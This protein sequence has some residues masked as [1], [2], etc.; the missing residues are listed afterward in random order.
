MRTLKYAIL[1]L[2]NNE[3]MTGY[4]IGKEF[5]KDLGEFWN[6]KHSQ[7][8]PEL[9]KL[10]DEGLIVYE[11]QISGEI[12]E[13]KMYSITEE[14]KEAF[15]KWL[16][17]AEPLEPTPKDVFRLRMY[18]SNHLDVPTRIHLLEHQLLQ[19]QERLQHLRKNN[20][21]HQ[22]IPPHDSVDFGDYFILDGAILRETVT[23]QWL[24]NFIQYCKSL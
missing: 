22:S 23:I 1:G 3:P 24:E 18:F 2:L 4:D 8:Y 16:K 19:H 5:S 6:A 10:F 13:K 11:I 21:R 9:K 17:Q 7:I 20:E 15:L 14:G 12:L